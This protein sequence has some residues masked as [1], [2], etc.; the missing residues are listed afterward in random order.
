MADVKPDAYQRVFFLACLLEMSLLGVAGIYSGLADQPLLGSIKW[1][2]A[3]SIVGVVA[4]VPLLVLF[5]AALGSAWKPMVEVRQFLEETVRPIFARWSVVQLAVISTLAGLSEEIFF[6]GALQGGLTKP[7]GTAFA[8]A[9][10]SAV[11]GLCH[12]V[13]RAYG[14]LA[15]C[16][17]I[18]FSTLWLLT[19]NLLT[20]IVTHALYDFIALL[21]FL[22]MHRPN[23]NG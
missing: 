14:V 9:V 10:A 22:R 5:R 19:D 6:R 23:R 15:A 1:R 17:G 13:N 16:I 4:A 2:A 21:Y 8:I 18:Y 11:F 3:D 20:P 7:F 12:L